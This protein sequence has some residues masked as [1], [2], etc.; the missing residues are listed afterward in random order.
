MAAIRNSLLAFSNVF[1]KSTTAVT[2]NF[3]QIRNIWIGRWMTRDVKRRRLARDYA[4]ERLRLVALKR[5]NILPAEIQTLATKQ[6]DE[7]IPRQTAL[8]QLTPRCA[9]TS[10]G[11]GTVIKWRISRIVFRHL[12]DYNKLSGVQRA[13]W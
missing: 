9:V 11:R 5:N 10:R 12:A 13:L 6:I 3:Q 8:R 7:T 1:S 2:S 4:P